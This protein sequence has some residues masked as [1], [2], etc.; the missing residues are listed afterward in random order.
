LLVQFATLF[1][2][3]YW[4]VVCPADSCCVMPFYLATCS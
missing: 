3:F 4:A 2:S 1:V